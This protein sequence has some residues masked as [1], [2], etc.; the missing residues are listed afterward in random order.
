MTIIFESLGG[1]ET[2]NP[3]AGGVS[4]RHRVRGRQ[5][6]LGFGEGAGGVTFGFRVTSS[7]GSEPPPEL[8]VGYGGVSSFGGVLG[9]MYAIMSS[10]GGISQAFRVQGLYQ[11]AEGSASGAISVPFRVRGTEALAPPPGLDFDL[12]AVESRFDLFAIQAGQDYAG[13]IARFRAAGSPTSGVV[14][15]TMVGESVTFEE[16]LFIIFRMA[17]AEGI[18]LSDESTFT[19][20]AVERVIGA[21]LLS[22][23]ATNVLEASNL[24][25]AALAMQTLADM[26]DKELVADGV[27]FAAAVSEV[28]TYVSRLLDGALFAGLPVD[29]LT[30]MA[31]VAETVAVAGDTIN[32]L[33]ALSL[34]EEGVSFALRM[35]VEGEERIAYVIN[36]TTKGVTSYQNYPFNSFAKIGGRFYGMADDGIRELEGSDDDGA[37][38]NWRW[39]L[40]QSALGTINEKR[41]QHAYLGFCSNGALRLQVIVTDP[42]TRKKEAHYYKLAAQPADAPVVGR[43]GIGQGLK[44]VYWGFGMEAI[45]GATFQMDLL[46]LVPII[47]GTALQGEGGGKK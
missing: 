33:E 39:R 44:T 11:P 27:A 21:V 20:T 17:V 41:M 22:G 1:D 34:I 31:L 14:L 40:A 46:R 37:P 12:A 30:M 36:T 32:A 25:V 23:L 3:G 19:Y 2:A 9:T 26:F 13:A 38:I 16:G 35:N 4:N 7:G 24:V 43:L 8:S 47:L 15:T 42:K 18:D 28:V 10:G 5:T 45:D 6:A 29:T